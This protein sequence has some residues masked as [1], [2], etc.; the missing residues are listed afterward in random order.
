MNVTTIVAKIIFAQNRHKY[1]SG[2][3]NLKVIKCGH[4]NTFAGY[5]DV[6]P[7]NPR[8]S[9]LL[10][11][12]FNKYRADQKPS[13]HIK[14]DVVLCDSTN[15]I[16]KKIDETSAWNW[17]QGSRLQWIDYER[18]IY[19]VYENRKLFSRVYNI[20]TKDFI[21]IPISANAVCSSFI[22][23]LDYVALSKYSEYGYNGI[24]VSNILDGV[25]MAK[26]DTLDI[27]T[28]FQENEVLNLISSEIS[29]RLVKR[30]INHILISPDE[31]QFIFIYRG[32][33]DGKRA[34]YLFYYDLKN[35]KLEI[36]FQAASLISHYTW[37]N[38][39]EII[40]WA[41]VDK[42]SGYYCL[43]VMSGEYVLIFETPDDGH[44]TLLD[45]DTM[46][47]DTYPNYL[48]SNQLLTIYDFT[49]KDSREILSVYHPIIYKKHSRCDLHPSIS[50]DH[51]LFQ[52]DMRNRGKRTV[53]VGAMPEGRSAE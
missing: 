13:V 8:N 31:T 9:N 44:P 37:K 34:D 48:S 14:T 39:Y 25:I 1:S 49:N 5:Y 20:E 30:H 3:H 53:G 12:H 26:F 52:I 15:S 10:A 51:K 29:D 24:D 38:H 11:L 40:V 2:A 28:V 36:L 6:S 47:T 16:C 33:L 4:G 32:E 41:V 22:L 21:N 35:K 42:R 27:S 7:F 18:I 19:N 23:T 43:N 17:Q 46:L 45:E 50:R